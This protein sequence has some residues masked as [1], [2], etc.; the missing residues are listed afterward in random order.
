VATI[1]QGQ[2]ALVVIDVQNDVMVNAW[3]RDDVIANIVKL[4]DRARETETPVIFVQHEDEELVKDTGGW[5]FVDALVRREDEPL[6]HKQYPDAFVETEF[7]RTLADLDVS[8]LVVT[9]AQSMACI[10]STTNR[11]MAE[12]YDLTLV[13]DAHTTDDLDFGG[14]VLSAEQIVGY[15]NLCLQ[16]TPYPGQDIRVAPHDTVAFGVPLSAGKDV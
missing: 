12:G 16:F 10:R 2:T 4:I 15:T 13:S 6:I 5:R 3:R 9:G 1:R 7:E 8:H 11:A 14:V